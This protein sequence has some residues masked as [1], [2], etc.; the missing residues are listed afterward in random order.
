HSYLRRLNLNVGWQGHA[1][2]TD[3]L[4]RQ[5]RLRRTVDC[6]LTLETFA[7]VTADSGVA[8]IRPGVAAS[9]PTSVSVALRH[10]LEDKLT[11]LRRARDLSNAPTRLAPLPPR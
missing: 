9:L 4:T 5:G 8:G 11:S 6:A 3:D 2:P 10:E 1:M 7:T